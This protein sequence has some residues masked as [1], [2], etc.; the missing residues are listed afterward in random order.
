MCG[1]VTSELP[2]EEWN[3]SPSR[4]VSCYAF[5]MFLFSCVICYGMHFFSSPKKADCPVDE[6]TEAD[7]IL[8]RDTCSLV[9]KVNLYEHGHTAWFICSLII[10][11]KECNKEK[12]PPYE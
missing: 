3:M 4:H 12:E 1:E 9:K 10:T 11:S 8:S 7:Q 2:G 5:H 6:E